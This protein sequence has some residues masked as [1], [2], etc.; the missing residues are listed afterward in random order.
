[1]LKVRSSHD[2]GSSGFVAWQEGY[3][4]FSVQKVQEPN[5]NSAWVQMYS[6]SMGVLLL[7]F[8]FNLLRLAGT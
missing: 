8:S 2:L 7:F 6:V 1:M 3:P 4:Q 5:W